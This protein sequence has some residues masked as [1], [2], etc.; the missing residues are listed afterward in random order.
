MSNF[1]FNPTPQEQSL[2][3]QIKARESGGNYGVT[4][5]Q[6]TC[7]KLMGYA[8][9][10]C[11][12]SGAYQFVN[13]TWQATAAATGAGTDCPTAASC[14]QQSQDI[15]ALYLLRTQ[16]TVPWGGASVYGTSSDPGGGPL[17]DLSGDAAST[18][19]SSILDQLTTQAATVGI[20]LTNPVTDA[21][22]AVAAIAAVLLIGRR[23]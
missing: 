6:A 10:T 2:L 3:N 5:S 16:G 7:D 23:I 9:A 1:I 15:N 19:T 4:I 17:V 8:G 20:D 12:A 18:P 21:I 22:V 14:D 13:A 11:T